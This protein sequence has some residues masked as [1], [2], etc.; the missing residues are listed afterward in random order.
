MLKVI[1]YYKFV[2]VKDPEMAMRWQ[3]ELCE[4]L[5]LKGRIIISPHGIN[6]TLGGDLEDLRR[7]KRE[8][9]KSVIFKGIT[10]KWSDGSGDDFPKLSIKVRDELVAFKAADEIKVDEKGVVGGGKHLKPEQLH[11]L[12]EEKGNEVVFFDGRNAYEASVGKFK[13]A[14]VPDTETTRDFVR[15]IESDKYNDIKDKPVVT[16]CTGGVRCEVLSALMKNRG[17]KDVYQIDGGIVKYGE[18]YGDE[19][20]WE[21]SLYIFD[22]RMSH[23]FSDKSKDIGVCVHCG[24]KTSNYENCANVACNKLVLICKDCHKQISLCNT[25][26]K[27]SKAVPSLTKVV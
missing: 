21:G 18:K 20:L 9:N 3:R 6:G 16:Y 22:Q 1:L 23:R 13:N 17:F 15:E 7:Y 8:M 27:A 2:P 4:R 10:Y 12:I 11:K 5:N 26:K 25:H 19:G 24:G 14:I